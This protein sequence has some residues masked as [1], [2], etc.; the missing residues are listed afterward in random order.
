[1]PQA[2]EHIPALDADHLK[3]VL[4]TIKQ[5][6]GL[7]CALEVLVV[8]RHVTCRGETHHTN[9]QF[10]GPA[11]LAV[12]EASNVAPKVDLVTLKQ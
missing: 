6:V 3:N 1:M 12:V 4:V 8:R 2:P 11:I 9:V 5:L 10:L 7:I